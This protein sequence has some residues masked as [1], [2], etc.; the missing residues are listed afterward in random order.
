MKWN[1]RIEGDVL[2]PEGKRPLV[3][4][5]TDSV[6][7]SGQ[8][9]IEREELERKY[10]EDMGGGKKHNNFLITPDSRGHNILSHT[11]DQVRSLD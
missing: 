10:D 9:C 3:R 5:R 2:K 7:K 1:S 6:L 4:P 8:I 11:S